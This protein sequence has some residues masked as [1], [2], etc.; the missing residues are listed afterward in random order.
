MRRA[1][2]TS[3]SIELAA[4]LAM[5]GGL[6]DA[7][8]YLGRG[9][10]FANAQTGNLL[11]LGVH[12][13]AGEWAQTIQY[14]MPVVFFALGVAVAHGVRCHCHNIRAHW[15][16]ICLAIEVVL[17]AT[18]AFVPESQN[19]LANSMTSLACGI[20]VQAFRKIHGVGFATT[21]CIGN[22]RAATH[23]L[24]EFFHSGNR[25]ALESSLL[26]YGTIV[27][28][29]CGAILGSRMLGLVG[30]RAILVS[31]AILV[32]ALLVMNWDREVG[33]AAAAE[34]QWLRARRRRRVTRDGE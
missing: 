5:S 4:L 29:V 33:T 17:L 8:S 1:T 16:Q 3:E 14:A 10:V 7:Y 28:F 22:L 11:L 25:K 6:M 2:Q 13:A 12:A 31:C 30:L 34:R 20:Q 26:H 19:L 21:M 9:K 24:T 27:C 15:R 23:G 18:V 32:V